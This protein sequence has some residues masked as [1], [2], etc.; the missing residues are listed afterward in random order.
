MQTTAEGVGA[1]PAV[2]QS[3]GK[4]PRLLSGNT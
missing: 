4:M 2:L 1:A 3:R